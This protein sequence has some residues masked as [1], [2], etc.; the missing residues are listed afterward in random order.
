MTTFFHS[1]A[2]AHGFAL[3]LL[4]PRARRAG[5]LAEVAAGY[6]KI[7]HRREI[8]RRPAGAGCAPDFGP[9]PFTAKRVEPRGVCEGREP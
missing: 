7:D 2:V 6:G 3:V 5:W 4:V 1:L 8:L 9:S